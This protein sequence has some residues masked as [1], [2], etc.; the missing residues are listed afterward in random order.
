MRNESVKSH[1]RHLQA[2]RLSA[3]DIEYICGLINTNY[4]WLILVIFHFLCQENHKL[5][6]S[7]QDYHNDIS[8]TGLLLQVLPAFCPK[9]APTVGNC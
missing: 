9:L 8:V 1:N 2:N 3:D 7:I 5:S 6:S 4:S